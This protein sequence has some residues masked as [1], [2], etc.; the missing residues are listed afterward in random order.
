M[1]YLLKMVIFHG[2]VSH[3][4]RVFSEKAVKWLVNLSLERVDQK[5]NGMAM[6][7]HW[8]IAGLTCK[9]GEIFWQS[10]SIDH[11]TSIDL[12]SRDMGFSIA[13]FDL[14]RLSIKSIKQWESAGKMAKISA[15][16]REELLNRID[17]NG[18][19]SHVRKSIIYLANL[20]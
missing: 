3:N 18:T 14:K 17:P 8:F 20:Q 19:L 16:A 6:K 13:I 1:V 2:Y 10:K 12:P 5:T 11:Q 4:Q 15:I 9:T 7:I